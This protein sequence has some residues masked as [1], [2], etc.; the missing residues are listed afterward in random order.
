MSREVKQLI[1]SMLEL[2]PTKRITA[3]SALRHPWVSNRDK[4]AQAVH[5]QVWRSYSE[6]VRHVSILRKR[7]IAFASS[8]RGA[9]WRRRWRPCLRRTKSTARS[10]APNHRFW[11]TR[12]HGAF[13][14]NFWISQSPIQRA[15]IRTR[16][17]WRRVAPRMRVSLSRTHLIDTKLSRSTH[18][19]HLNQCE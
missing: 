19:R 15:Q 13:K 7:W 8:M 2:D 10:R 12:E 3:G 9:R 17:Q 16:H 11:V 18:E 6:A 1:D 14:P 4:V 5:R